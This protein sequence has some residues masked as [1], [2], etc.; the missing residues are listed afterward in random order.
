MPLASIGTTNTNI[1]VHWQGTAESNGCDAKNVAPNARMFWRGDAIA[2]RMVGKYAGG[3]DTS[4]NPELKALKDEIRLVEE[5]E[6]C[7][8]SNYRSDVASISHVPC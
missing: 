2:F 1:W 5:H 3:A 4:F 7:S 6:E 8:G